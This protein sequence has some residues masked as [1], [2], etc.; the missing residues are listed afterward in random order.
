MTVLPTV[1]ADFCTVTAA[2][3]LSPIG[4]NFEEA[5]VSRE[6]YNF[7]FLDTWKATARLSV[8]YGL[9][10]EV[11]S[12]IHEAKHRTS[13]AIPI[14]PNGQIADFIAPGT[15]QLYVY[16]PHPPYAIDWNGAG[17]RLSVHYGLTNPTT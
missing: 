11:N 15:R 4:D 8:T 5:A 6:A 17:P 10:Y 3:S 14:G 1:T 7:Y 9:R 13:L 16:N 2:A 12:R